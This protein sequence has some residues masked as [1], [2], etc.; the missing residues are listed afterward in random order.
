MPTRHTKSII[1][2]VILGFTELTHSMELKVFKVPL[3]GK[4]QKKFGEK[5][6]C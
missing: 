6:I 3:N 4:A 1:G 5:C 2:F